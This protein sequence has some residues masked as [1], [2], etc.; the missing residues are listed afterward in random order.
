M[1]KTKMIKSKALII[2]IRNPELGKVKTR[3]ARKLGD[4]KALQIY[5][6][7]LQH[8]R[9]KVQEVDAGR[10]LFYSEKI[11]SDDDWPAAQF[12][13]YLQY[14]GNLGERMHYAFK[15][16]LQNHHHAIIVGSDIAQL[17][18]SIINKAFEILQ[19]KDY[20]IGPAMDGGYYLLG[21]K[22][23]S[24]ELFLDMEWSTSEVFQH[25]IGRIEKHGRSWEAVDTLSDIDYAEDW[26]RYGWEV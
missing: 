24:P 13:K 11:A 15:Q 21:M 7:L 9:Q 20:V 8:T 4:E 14:E 26:E 16:A 17:K 10:L 1:A 25:T 6:A 18:A 19:H 23:P 3:L 22:K 2:F 12:E 5:K